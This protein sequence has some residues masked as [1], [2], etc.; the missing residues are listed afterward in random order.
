MAKS[1]IVALSNPVTPERADDFQSWY[2]GV[3]LPQ[4]KAHTG[5]NNARVYRAATEQLFDDDPRY[6]FMVT[7][8]VEDLSGTIQRMRAAAPKLD[9]SEFFDAESFVS[10]AYDPVEM[11]P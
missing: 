2:L 5:N 11:A 4:I 1:M 6:R 9:F 10:V 8:E 7:Y 3:H